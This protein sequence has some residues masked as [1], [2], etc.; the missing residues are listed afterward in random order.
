MTAAAIAFDM[1]QTLGFNEAE[2]EIVI[3]LD[4]RDVDASYWRRVLREVRAL[5]IR[6]ADASGP[7]I[8]GTR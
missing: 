3:A 4:R 8:G 5:R 2:G 7:S 1:V 6:H